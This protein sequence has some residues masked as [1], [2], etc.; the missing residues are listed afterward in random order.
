MTP[1]EIQTVPSPSVSARPKRAKLSGWGRYPAL[2]C[3]L[4]RP[5]KFSELAAIVESNSTS[6]IAR[7]AGRAYGDAAV[8][9][10]NRVVDVTRLDRMISFDPES[11]TLRA[12]AGVTLAGII[13]V[14]VPRGFFPPVVPGTRY[15]TLGGSIAADIHGKGHHRDFS[16]A[17]H[18]TSFNLMLASG[19]IRRCSREEHADLFWGSVG[20]M[21]LTGVILEVEL[22]LRRIESAWLEGE[23]IRAPNLDAAFEA[24]ERTNSQYGNSVAWI[25]CASNKGKLGRSVLTVAN[26]AS[27]ASLP[28]AMRQAPFAIA[29]KFRPAV[30]FDLPNFALNPLTVRAFNGVIYATHREQAGPAR[31]DY[32]SFFFPLDSIHDWYR[33]YGKRGF[34]QYQCVWPEAESR[35]GLIEILDAISTSRR[36]SFLTVLKKFGAQDGMLSFPMP[37]YTLALDFPVAGGLLEFLDRLDAMV[38]KRGGR[39]YL[40]KDARMR[41]ETF[42]A[43]YPNL[44]RWQQIKAA[45]DPNNR[46]SSSLARRIGMIPA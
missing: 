40:A 13:E 6:L 7:G 43:M 4:Y 26:F 21:G 5:E 29:P 9:G 36:G 17:A 32:Q 24:F 34:V 41:P 23:L 12:E 20:A 31:F 3:D 33:I 14:F 16:L 30:P 38:L 11:A 1:A 8:N 39:V 27:R 44:A 10:D 25:D 28:P 37:G 2:E 35:A 15:V 46:F 18:V 42:R 45:A 19:E 22:K